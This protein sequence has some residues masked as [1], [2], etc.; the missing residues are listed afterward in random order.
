MSALLDM[1]ALLPRAVKAYDRTQRA[2]R[3][4]DAAAVSVFPA[5]RSSMERGRHFLAEAERRRDHEQARQAVACFRQVLAR[6]PLHLV[7]ST[8]APRPR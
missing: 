3:R 4:G 8:E 6:R 2:A 7:E 1:H 5:M